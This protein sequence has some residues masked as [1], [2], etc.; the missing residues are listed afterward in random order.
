MAAVPV[1]KKKLLVIFILSFFSNIIIKTMAENIMATVLRTG[2]IG[3]KDWL[4]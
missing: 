2:I 3:L 1:N 4:Y